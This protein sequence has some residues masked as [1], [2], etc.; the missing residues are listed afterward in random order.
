MDKQLKP[1]PFCGN[2]AE[3]YVIPQEENPEWYKKVSFGEY[4]VQV[5]FV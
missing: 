4:G 5:S 1:C 3:L 2:P